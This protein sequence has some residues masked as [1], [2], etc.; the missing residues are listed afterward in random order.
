VADALTHTGQIAILRRLA[1]CPIR[2][3]NYY[4]A[5]ISAG[6]V[7]HDQATPAREF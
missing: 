5:E 6:R 2:A 4:R 7:G 1:G 3:E